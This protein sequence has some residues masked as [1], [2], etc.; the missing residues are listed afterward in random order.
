MKK[1]IIIVTVI[2]LLIGVGYLVFININKTKPV[3]CTMEAKL[4]PDGSSVGRTGPN[5]E[6]AT[7]PEEMSIAGW[8]TFI[9]DKQGIEFQYP[10]KLPTNYMNVTND[11]PPKITISNGTL[12]CS[13]TPSADNPQE[14]IIKGMI[15]NR[16]YCVGVSSEG[17]AGSI[18]KTYTYVTEKDSKL[19]TANF[20]V[21]YPQ[22]VNYD[23]PQK[24]QCQNEQ[25]IF[26]LDGTADRIIQTVNKYDS[27]YKNIPY[28]I[29]NAKYFGNDA[30]GDLNGDGKEDVA[31]LITQNS[32]GS[33]TFYY[34]V[35]ALKNTNGYQVTNT[36]LLGDRIAP[37]TT[38]I[39]NGEIIVNYADR[40]PSEPMTAIPFVG[41]SKY[42]KVV[43]NKLVEVQ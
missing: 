38:E 36:L 22:C 24:T 35:V 30:F 6:F 34:V 12:S 7:C 14:Q 29:N 28:G 1:T 33:G 13:E 31:F 4:C 20:T 16:D 2:V 21:Q 19:I 26:D 17:A 5:C 9:D 10:E 37:Q 41:V 3:A 25:S 39:Q 18:Y 43:S 8:K 11:W 15:N 23:N 42:F 27:S 32:E 40:K